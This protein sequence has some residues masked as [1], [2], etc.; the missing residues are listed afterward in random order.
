MLKRITGYDYSPDLEEVEVIERKGI[1]HPDSVADIIAESFSNDYSKYYQKK[2]GKIL[3]HWFDKVLIS[4]GE[5]ILRPG[6]GSIIKKPKVYLFGKITRVSND[7]L[8]IEEFFKITVFRVMRDI[9]G[10]ED[11]IMPDIVVDTN[12][13]VGAEHPISFYNTNVYDIT[14]ESDDLVSNDT[15]FC[16]GYYPYTKLEHYVCDLENY[17][18]S[19]S[20]K[21][22]HYYTGFDVKVLAKRIKNNIDI[23]VCIPFIAARTESWALYFELKKN[24]E[25]DLYFFTKKFKWD[26]VNI[27]LNTKDREGKG[28]LT[29]YGSAFDKG[30]FGVVGRGNRYL[31]F[32]TSCRGETQEAYSGKNPVIH[33]GKLFSIIAHRIARKISILD[34]GPVKVIICINN[35]SPI[36]EPESVFVFTKDKKISDQHIRGLLLNEFNNI[37]NITTHIINLNPVEEF[38][39]KSILLS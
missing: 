34:G 22:K 33:S 26:S 37:H 7:D 32:I 5:A 17:I 31:G 28:F 2:Y 24:I 36:K 4:G 11:E 20:F 18:N 19:K 16:N 13:G 10:I 14:K 21:E 27:H 38:V 1:G 6:F 8:N 35:G 29:L 15:I 39:T 9:F 23:T 3:N 30:D 25:N 12:S